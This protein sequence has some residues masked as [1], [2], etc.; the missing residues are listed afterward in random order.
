MN[1]LKALNQ[2]KNKPMIRKRKK[3]NNEDDLFII[4][5]YIEPT[6]PIVV[7]KVR[8]IREENCGSEYNEEPKKGKCGC[9]IF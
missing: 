8:E 7:K 2:E 4:P 9:L 1:Y 3:R 5:N 6:D